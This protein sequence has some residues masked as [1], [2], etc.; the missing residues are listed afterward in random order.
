MLKTPKE[1]ILDKTTKV[2]VPYNL[3]KSNTNHKTYTTPLLK[4]D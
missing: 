4:D 2:I 1:M 3:A